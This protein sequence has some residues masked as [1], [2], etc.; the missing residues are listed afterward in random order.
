MPIKTGSS[1]SA[2][3]GITNGAQTAIVVK[4]VGSLY[5]T[6]Q[7][8][9]ITDA[10]VDDMPSSSTA[11]TLR[12]IRAGGKDT[13]ASIVFVHRN[14]WQGSLV[15]DSDTS[16][17]TGNDHSTAYGSSRTPL[18]Q[19]GQTGIPWATEANQIGSKSKFEKRFPAGPGIT[20]HTAKLGYSSGGSSKKLDSGV[21]TSKEVFIDITVPFTEGGKDDEYFIFFMEGDKNRG[22]TDGTFNPTAIDKNFFFFVDLE[23]LPDVTRNGAKVVPIFYDS[24]WNTPSIGIR[25]ATDAEDSPAFNR[26]YPPLRNK[27]HDPY[28]FNA[29]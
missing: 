14:T 8:I 6:N 21:G 1:F 19:T 17:Y 5:D 2:S 25:F 11:R 12:F 27:E 18:W 29:Q 20:Y 23:Q 9:T 4:S 22:A 3:I 26:K 15:T 24:Y 28:D 10:D 13:L 16:A 7:T